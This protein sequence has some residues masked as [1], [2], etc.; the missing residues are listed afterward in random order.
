MNSFIELPKETHFN[1]I[2]MGRYKQHALLTLKPKIENLI[3]KE[4]KKLQ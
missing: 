4:N 2:I 1:D 3:E